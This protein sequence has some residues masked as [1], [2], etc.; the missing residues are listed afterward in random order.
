MPTTYTSSADWIEQA[1]K[2]ETIFPSGLRKVTKK[3]I[4]PSLPQSD[5]P[6]SNIDDGVEFVTEESGFTTAYVHEYSLNVIQSPPVDQGEDTTVTIGTN[7]LAKI[8]LTKVLK[9]GTATKRTL[10]NKDI[11][12]GGVVN[13]VAILEIETKSFNYL[14][15]KVTK[16]EAKNTSVTPTPPSGTASSVILNDPFGGSTATRAWELSSYETTPYGKFFETSF[17][18][19]TTTSLEKFVDLT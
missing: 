3:Y 16:L 11:N 17:V 8:Y 6:K 15:E 9:T 10:R 18:Y 13:T 1:E 14:A 19:E 5:P 2:T 12:Q 7:P 4:S